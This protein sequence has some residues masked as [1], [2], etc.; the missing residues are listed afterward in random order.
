M[1]LS[2]GNSV[3]PW[4]FGLGP[5]RDGSLCFRVSIADAPRVLLY[6]YI[7]LGFTSTRLYLREKA[8]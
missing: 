5:L 7:T 1:C 3:Q 2:L 8:L 6:T 4:Q